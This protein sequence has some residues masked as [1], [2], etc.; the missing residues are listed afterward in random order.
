M[1]KQLSKLVLILAIISTPIMAAKDFSPI[2]SDHQ[3]VGDSLSMP[4]SKSVPMPE[5]L[6]ESQMSDLAVYIGEG[7]KM[8]LG[9]ANLSL[10][11][12]LS[13]LSDEYELNTIN[14]A[15]SVRK[16]LSIDLKNMEPTQLIN[17]LIKAWDCEWYFEDGVLSI[18][19]QNPVRVFTL[20][21]ISG[22]DLL[23]TVSK[24]S[25]LDGLSISEHSNSV[26]ARGP[27]EQLMQLDQLI[28][29]LDTAPL[30]VFIEA[31]IIETSDD[32]SRSIGVNLMEGKRNNDYAMTSTVSEPT[33]NALIDGVFAKVV[34]GD[35][36]AMI[37]ASV[38]NDKADVLANPRLM[39]T[40]HRTATI[41]TG[42]RLG[43]STV[44]QTSL[45]ST[46][47]IE[48]LETGIKLSFTPH[49]SKYGD[50]LMDIKPEVSDGRI[51]NNVPRES[52]TQTETQVMVKNGQ[53][54]IIGGLYQKKESNSQVGVPILSDI[55]ILNLLFQKQTV[56]NADRE[57]LILITPKIINTVAG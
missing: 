35:L 55:P 16:T 6:R 56:E 29:D 3:W 30:Q 48:F 9:F 37:S 27:I 4:I 21:Y 31:K 12:F 28:H 24:V 23:D 7:E 44:T 22:D 33:G 46:E 34:K 50:I 57:I 14:Y 43:Y 32:F 51:E 25:A 54:I 45:S 5:Q 41:I 8:S 17:T 20:D 19:E 10:K 18:F 47:Q 1:F 53:T 39:V 36:S 13:I 40:N 11:Q 15:Q 2:H 38:Q 52:T 26:V 42:Q 49:I